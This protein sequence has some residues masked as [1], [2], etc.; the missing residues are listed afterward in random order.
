[1]TLKTGP[2]ILLD[3]EVVMTL[4]VFLFR[5]RSSYDRISRKR[6]VGEMS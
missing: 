2:N 5:Y 1:M 4:W 6:R 3:G